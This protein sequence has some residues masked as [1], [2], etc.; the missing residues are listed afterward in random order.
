[1]LFKYGAFNS[2]A[3]GLLLFLSLAIQACSTP[4]EQFREAMQRAAEYCATHKI[5]PTNNQCGIVKLKAAD[6]L[7]TEEGRFAHA[8]KIPNPVPEDSEYQPRMTPEEYFDHLCKTEAGEFIFKTVENVGGIYMMRPRKRATDDEMQHLY[9]MEDP[10]GYID[11]EGRDPAVIFVHPN[12]FQFFEIPIQKNIARAS[13]RPSLHSTFFEPPEPGDM[14]ERHLGYDGK[15]WKTKRREY[16]VN[17][18]SRYGYTWRGITRPYDREL[19]IAGGELIVLDLESHEVLAVRRGYVRIE[20]ARNTVAGITWLNGLTCPKY[21]YRNGRDKF[22][23]FSYWF[24]GKV[25]RP[26]NYEL[27]FKEITYG[28]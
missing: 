27:S 21:G 8:I 9:A 13:R 26:P 23:D 28:K 16:D 11:T 22:S 2:I 12:K 19:G 7:A 20:G 24:I 25:L 4:G 10:Y 17:R 5:A 1:M 6:P 3:I 18:K 14:L 15:D